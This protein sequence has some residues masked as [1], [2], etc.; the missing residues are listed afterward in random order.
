MIVFV[1]FY[2][3][4]ITNGIDL[5]SFS[6]IENKVFALILEFLVQIVGFSIVN[7][8]IYQIAFHIISRKWINENKDKFLQGRWLHIH[9][10]DNVRIGVVDIKQNFLDIEAKAFNISPNGVPDKGKTHWNYIDSEIQP[11]ALGSNVALFGCYVTRKSN[12]SNKQG[13][14]TLYFEEGFE[15]FPT[16]LS[17]SFC[18]CL[19]FEKNSV[20]E[21]KDGTGRLILHKIS[22]RLNDYLY[23][24]GIFKE[25]NLK[26]ILE[27]KDFAGEPF[28]QDLKEVMSQL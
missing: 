23:P 19:N 2:L 21:I 28:V 20:K 10:K 18:D 4:L 7:V 12:L 26:G 13:I 16:K 8:A 1:D 11:K 17:G 22:P 25:E 9:G 24:N 6:F 14:H 27:N 15:D 5:V 3:L